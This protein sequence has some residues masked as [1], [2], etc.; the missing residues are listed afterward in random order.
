MLFVIINFRL[1]PFFGN[2]YQLVNCWQH[3]LRP[4]LDQCIL[5]HYITLR[6]M[7]QRH[8]FDPKLAYLKSNHQELSDEV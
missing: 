4:S 7:T 2:G 3:Q 1:R 8:K 6:S 5:F